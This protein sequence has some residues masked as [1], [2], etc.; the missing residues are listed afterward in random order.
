MKFEMWSIWHFIY[1]LSPFIILGILLLITR[2]S[3]TRTK[4]IIGIVIGVLSLAIILVRNIDI[5]IRSGWSEEVIPFQVCHIG[6]IIVGLALIL[7]KKWLILVSFCFNMIPAILA[8]IFA[9]ALA[10]YDT[11]LKIRPQT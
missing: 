3:S 8:M 4:Y 1:I 6:S 10:N 2:K 9:D 7:K 5:L 11:L